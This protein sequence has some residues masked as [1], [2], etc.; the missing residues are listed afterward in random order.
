MGVWRV[1]RGVLRGECP[2]LQSSRGGEGRQGGLSY[3]LQYKVRGT[4]TRLHCTVIHFISLHCT[5]L[6][7]LKSGREAEVPAWDFIDGVFYHALA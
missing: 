2:E 4:W 7:S 3:L 5:A 6:F 1:D